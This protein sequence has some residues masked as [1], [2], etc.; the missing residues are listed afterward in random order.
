MKVFFSVIQPFLLRMVLLFN[1]IPLTN[2][3]IRKRNALSNT[4]LIILS[5]FMSS[6]YLQNYYYKINITYITGIKCAW[7][8]HQTTEK[9]LTFK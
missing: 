6:S 4:K 1:N 3:R 8:Q 2:K 5:Y 9:Y 7:F